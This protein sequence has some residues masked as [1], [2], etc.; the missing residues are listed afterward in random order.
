MYL[1]IMFLGGEG[2][3]DK[4]NAVSAAFLAGFSRDASLERWL[5]GGAS[6]VLIP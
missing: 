5:G 6:K 1:Q 2:F 3:I 4:E